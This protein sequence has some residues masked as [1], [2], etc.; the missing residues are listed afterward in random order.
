M[1]ADLEKQVYTYVASI[2]EKVEVNYPAFKSLIREYDRSNNEEREPLLQCLTEAS[3]AKY[4]NEYLFVGGF[5]SV[6]SS[7]GGAMAALMLMPSKM[8]QKNILLFS[9]FATSMLFNQYVECKYLDL[10][11][12]RFEYEVGKCIESYEDSIYG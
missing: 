9:G 1:K 5:F 2:Y 10:E 8:A 3:K 12:S 4:F 11:N 7:F 6:A